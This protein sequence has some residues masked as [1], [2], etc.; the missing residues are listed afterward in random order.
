VKSVPQG[1]FVEISALMDSWKIKF[2]TLVT[3]NQPIKFDMFPTRDIP[4]EIRNMLSQK[5]YHDFILANDHWQHFLVPNSIEMAGN[6]VFPLAQIA[7]TPSI[8]GETV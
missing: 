3:Q 1:D 8:P 7:P 2:Q 5:A 4:I 6:A